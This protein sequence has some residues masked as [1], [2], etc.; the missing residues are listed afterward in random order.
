MN[1]FLAMSCLQGR[2]MR[3]AFD[4]LAELNIDGIQLT[5]GNAPTVNFSR[6]IQDSKTPTRTHHGYSDYKML[7]RVWSD[8][9]ALLGDW[10]SVHPPTH[11]PEM[12]L[13]EAGFQHCLEVM[14]PGQPL[15]TG[16]AV[17]QALDAGLKLAVDISHIFIQITKGVMTKETWKALQDYENI[18]E[19]HVSANGGQRDSHEVIDKNCFGLEWAQERSTQNIPIIF[20]AYLHKTSPAMRESQIAIIRGLL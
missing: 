2:P 16:P 14:Y 1:L 15:G 13:P 5:P 11:A 9:Y 17:R 3:S 10:D 7:S 19:I 8:N 4:E 20:E 18:Q 6:H 12:W